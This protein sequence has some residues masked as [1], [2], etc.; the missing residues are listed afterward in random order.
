M[1]IKCKLFQYKYLKL[2]KLEN[3]DSIEKVIIK[4]NENIEMLKELYDFEMPFKQLKKKK[5]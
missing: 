4:I 3:D 5:K 1:P 2:Q